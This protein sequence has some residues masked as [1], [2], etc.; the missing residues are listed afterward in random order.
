MRV[1]RRFH[2]CAMSQDMSRILTR[3]F[4]DTIF[5]VTN[6]SI[7]LSCRH[8]QSHLVAHPNSSNLEEQVRDGLHS[9][10][11]RRV[12]SPGTSH[13]IESTNGDL[14]LGKA[15]LRGI[16]SGV[17]MDEAVRVAARGCASSV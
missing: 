2:F 12:L 14:S 16:G 11:Q 1:L 15:L 8:I 17:M 10:E 5:F 13:S 6:K 7:A 4:Y 3:T 9:V